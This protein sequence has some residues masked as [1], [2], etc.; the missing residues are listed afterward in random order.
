MEVNAGKS[1]TAEV[2]GTAEGVIGARWGTS[3]GG[4]RGWPQ[5]W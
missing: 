5:G 2:G 3:G 1:R 4:G